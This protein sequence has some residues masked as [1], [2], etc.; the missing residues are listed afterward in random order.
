MELDSRALPLTRGQLDIWLAQEPGR[1]ASEVAAGLSFTNRA[2]PRFWER[3]RPGSSP[4][5]LSAPMGGAHDERVHS[6]LHDTWPSVIL[7]TSSARCRQR[8]RSVPSHRIQRRPWPRS[9]HRSSRCLVTSVLVNNAGALWTCPTP[10]LLLRDSPKVQNVS[11]T[12]R[13]GQTSGQRTQGNVKRALQNQEDDYGDRSIK[14]VWQN[15]LEESASLTQLEGSGTLVGFEPPTS[16]RDLFVRFSDASA[17]RLA[18]RGQRRFRAVTPAG[19]P[20][21]V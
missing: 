9:P 17:E 19:Q 6:V 7:T 1:S 20:E 15:K 5:P 18:F 4:V 3:C 8:R 12:R 10:T 21:M 2:S 16:R 11:R 14:A 13:C